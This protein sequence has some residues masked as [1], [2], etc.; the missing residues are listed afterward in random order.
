MRLCTNTDRGKWDT[1]PVRS[2]GLITIN[3][4][5]IIRIYAYHTCSNDFKKISWIYH[6]YMFNILRL[7]ILM[8]AVYYIHY[9]F[10]I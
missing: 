4:N 2:D 3:K 10:C 8:K 7:N 9:E 6:Y 5:N 1:R